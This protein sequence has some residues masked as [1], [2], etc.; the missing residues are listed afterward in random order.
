MIMEGAKLHKSHG[1]DEI[2]EPE[3]EKDNIQ[4]EAFLIVSPTLKNES[5]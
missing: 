3:L 2:S 4:P 1:H 5:G